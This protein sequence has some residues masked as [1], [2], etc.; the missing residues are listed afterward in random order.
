MAEVGGGPCGG[1]LCEK[2]RVENLNNPAAKAIPITC[3]GVFFFHRHNCNLGDPVYVIC[4]VLI[5]LKAELVRLFFWAALTVL[6][7]PSSLQMYALLLA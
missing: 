1:A 5:I 3:F 7:L 2:A 4:Q 6:F